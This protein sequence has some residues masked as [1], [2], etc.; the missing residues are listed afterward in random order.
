MRTLLLLTTLCIQANAFGVDRAEDGPAI[1]D[2]EM[3]ASLALAEDHMDQEALDNS[4]G[5]EGD[6]MVQSATRNAIIGHRD[7]KWADNTIPYTITTD[8][9][10]SDRLVVARAILALQ[11]Q[12]CLRFVKRS[13]QADYISIVRPQQDYKCQSSVGRV[14]G[15]Q[16]LSLGFG[17][18]QISTVIHEMLHA[19]GFYHEQGREDRDKFLKVHDD[20]IIPGMERNFKKESN[21]TA[22]HFNST[23]DY[24]SIMHY[25]PTFFSKNRKVTLEVIKTSLPCANTIG[26]ATHMSDTDIREI[27]SLYKC[28]GYAQVGNG[29]AIKEKVC[30]DTAGDE[31]AERVCKGHCESTHISVNYMKRNCAKSCNFCSATPSQ[32]CCDVDTDQYSCDELKGRGY[33]WTSNSNYWYMSEHCRKTCGFC[34]A[35]TVVTTTTT[36]KMTTTTTTTTTTATTTTAKATLVCS[37]DQQSCDKLKGLG[38]CET[39]HKYYWYMSK[40]CRKT[41]GICNAGTVVTTTTKATTAKTTTTTTTTTTT[42]T[43]TTAKAT[44]VCWDTTD[45]QSCDK[46]KGL[47]LCETTHKYYRYMSKYCRK[48]CGICN[49]GTVVTTTTKATTAKT[50]TTTTTTTTTVSTTTAKATSNCTD[51]FPSDCVKLARMGDG[52]EDKYWGGQMKRYCSK[53]CGYCK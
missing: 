32:V 11:T 41:C 43:T 48:T 23:Y 22:T 14:G 27:N 30:Y 51:D 37:T 31:C 33:C 19:I 2:E 7:Y 9:T 39:T 12:T 4:G 45:Q 38:L 3:L 13:S 21:T 52:C 15:K 53:T 8:F 35:G 24:C 42:A 40:C 20:N 36:A 17:C 25:G 34:T 50:T 16:Y 46:L 26:E 1:S 29:I 47:G 10:A 44:L 18:M 28:D 6:M 49:A 5:L